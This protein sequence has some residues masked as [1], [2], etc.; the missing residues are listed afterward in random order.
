MSYLKS[1]LI[2]LYQQE[3]S[4]V[5]RENLAHLILCM[6]ELILNKQRISKQE[7]LDNFKAYS[8]FML[9]LKMVYFVLKNMFKEEDLTSNM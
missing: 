9:E 4:P 2:G 8:D 1:H 3:A 6:D 5:K 7:I